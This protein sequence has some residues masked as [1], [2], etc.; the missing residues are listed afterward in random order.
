MLTNRKRSSKSEWVFPGDQ[1][2]APILVT[3]LDHQHVVVCKALKL[4]KDFVIHSLRHTMLTRFGEAG[5]DAFSIMKI[6]GHTSVTVSHA[7][8]PSNYGRAGTRVRTFAESQQSK[9]HGRRGGNQGRRHLRLIGPP[10]F[11][12]S[13]KE[14]IRHILPSH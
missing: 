9:V 2:D 12:H 3:S 13:Q 11:P 14:D 4:P 5:A 7:V 8:R 10:N 6:A 1:P